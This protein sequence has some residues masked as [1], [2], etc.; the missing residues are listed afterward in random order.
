MGLVLFVMGLPGKIAIKRNHPHAEAVNVMGW[1]GFL[2]VVPWVHAFM[3][4]FHDSV[5]IDLRRFPEEERDAIRKEISRL[6]GKPAAPEAS[7][8]APPADETKPT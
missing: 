5:T 3:W 6:G 4:A 1:M 8:P 2:A 7:Q